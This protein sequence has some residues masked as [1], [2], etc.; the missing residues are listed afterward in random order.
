MWASPELCAESAS[1]RP[2][3]GRSSVR[4]MRAR[5]VLLALIGV[6]VLQ[7][8]SG[9]AVLEGS[10]R[11]SLDFASGSPLQ[12]L[13]VTDDGRRGELRR[14]DGRLVRELW[15]SPVPTAI[16]DV[17]ARW[18]RLVGRSTENAFRQAIGEPRRVLDLPIGWQMYLAIDA[19][20]ERIAATSAEAKSLRIISFDTG[21]LLAEHQCPPE[22][23]CSVVAFDRRDRDIVWLSTAS[24][25]AL[26]RF[27]LK[28]GTYSQVPEVEATTMRWPTVWWARD[29]A[30]CPSTGETLRPMGTWLDVET[31]DGR[32]ERVVSTKGYKAPFFGDAISPI[33]SAVFLP[34]CRYVVFIFYFQE[35]LLDLQTLEMGRVPGRVVAIRDR[36]TLAD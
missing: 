22:A 7:A 2:E 1:C 13:L 28:D 17:D 27:N 3:V 30:R 29:R 34:G 16:S 36:S 5:L 18:T 31:A 15:D 12:L 35:H 9:T 8:C 25:G 32:R 4:R 33:N 21:A 10:V 23:G 20:G 6:A 24:F 26:L 14:L 11:P 19:T